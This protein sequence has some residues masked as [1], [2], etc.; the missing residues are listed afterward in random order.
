MLLVLS[1]KLIFLYWGVQPE[2]FIL[3]NVTFEEY[4]AEAEYNDTSNTTHAIITA[5]MMLFCCPSAGFCCPKT[6]PHHYIGCLN[7]QMTS[8][9]GFVTDSSFNSIAR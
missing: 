9:I 5:F 2:A 1:R 3:C 8:A 4:A 7:L 6:C